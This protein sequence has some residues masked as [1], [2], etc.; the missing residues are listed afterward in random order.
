MRDADPTTFQIIR[1]PSGWGEMENKKFFIDYYGP[2]FADLEVSESHPAIFSRCAWSRDAKHYY[3]DV[4]R[5][6]GA[7]YD[8]F[9]PIDK[10]LAKDKG[11]E[12]HGHL[13]KEEFDRQMQRRADAGRAKNGK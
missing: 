10:W 12:Y 9:R 11:H 4:A 2:G 7:D 3:Y 8:T 6:E 1:E 5:V 13:R